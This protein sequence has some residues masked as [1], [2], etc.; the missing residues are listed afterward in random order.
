MHQGRFRSAAA[1]SAKMEPRSADG[2]DLRLE[3]Q[4]QRGL[5]LFL[6]LK[7]PAQMPALLQ[8]LEALQPQTRQALTN[9]HYVHFARFLPARD[10]SA[11]MVI[12]VYDGDL[13]SYLMDFVATM[14]EIFTAILEFVRDA[15][16]LPV[17]RYPREFCDFVK[18]N[19]LEVNPWSAYPSMTVLDIL[20]S[21][22]PF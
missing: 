10:G 3:D 21:Q 15:P 12:T 20:Q 6:V 1:P 22:R 2:G 17:S 8:C 19:N 16:R 13:D 14:G 9:L 7:S 5:N 18:R 11:L 4:V